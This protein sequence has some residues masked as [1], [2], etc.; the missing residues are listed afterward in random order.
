LPATVRDHEVAI[1]VPPHHPVAT[2]GAIKRATISRGYR[3]SDPHSW[4]RT[5]DRHPSLIARTRQRPGIHE[6]E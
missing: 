4:S 5:L 6:R 2:R 3:F 1:L